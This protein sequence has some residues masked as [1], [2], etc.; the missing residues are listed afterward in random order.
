MTD[1]I[2]TQ[3]RLAE[4][5]TS[6]ATGCL[7]V[8]SSTGAVG[9]IYLLFGQPF[10]ADSPSGEGE[11]AMAEALN[12]SNAAVSFDDK[13]KLPLT[14]TIATTPMPDTSQ[15]P[16][17]ERMETDPR[18]TAMSCVS[19]AGGVLT[20]FAP[21]TFIGIA[22][23]THAQWAPPAAVISL[24]V[25]G[26]V[27]VAGL[28]GFRRVFLHEAVKVATGLPKSEIP[29]VVE[30][31][32]GVIAGQPELV[33]TTAARCLTGRIG[34]CLVEFY[35]GGVQISRGADRPEPR[36]QFAYADLAQA[37]LLDVA[38]TGKTTVHQ[39]YVRLIAA[40]PRMA[41]LFKNT[42]SV[43]NATSLIFDKLREH[44][45]TTYSEELDS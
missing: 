29:M 38:S 13:A 33:V 9:H 16:G 39:Y 23:A 43:S 7:T 17:G 35:P 3:A 1:A 31:A 32:G 28:I 21:V 19:L 10:H 6:R 12:W 11:P 30:A 20:F 36:W 26:A 5:E 24:F 15:S 37:E 27:W 42:W 40:N 25:F 45:V 18:V 8:R 2:A 14:Q 4:L 41:F 34:K 22:A 44:G